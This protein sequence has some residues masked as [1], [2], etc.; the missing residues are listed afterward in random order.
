MDVFQI[1]SNTT[2]AISLYLDFSLVA[3]GD[4]AKHLLYFEDRKKFKVA[5]LVND[6]L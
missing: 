1:H 5:V 3:K 2:I 4:E 6:Y